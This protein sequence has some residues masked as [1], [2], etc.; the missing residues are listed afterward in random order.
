M[1]EDALL[2]ALV[3]GTA[4][5]TGLPFFRALVQGLSDALGTHGAWITEYLPEQRRLW[6]IALRLGG[7]WIPHYEYAVAGTPCGYSIEQRE[8]LFVKDRVADLFPGDNDLRPLGAVSY[9]GAGIFDESGSRVLGHLAVLHTEPMPDSERYTRIFRVFANR[10]GAELPRLIVEREQRAKSEELDGE[11]ESAMDAILILNQDH[12]IVR[13]NAA[14]AAA[15]GTADLAGEMVDRFVSVQGAEKLEPLLQDLLARAGDDHRQLWIPGGVEARSAAGDKF[16]V[17]GT[18]SRFELN[19]NRFATLI[20]RNISDR[21]AAEAKLRR[22]TDQSDYLREE[23]DHAF[24]EIIGESPPMRRLVGEITEVAR[25]DVSVLISGETGTG[26]EL[27]ARAVHRASRRSAAPLIKVNCAAIP[28]QLIESEFFGHEKGAFTGALARR[29]GRFS[30]ADGGTLFLDEIGELP[31]GL[32]AKLLRVLQEGEFEPVGSSRTVKV[33]VRV[34]AATNRDLR[35][36]STE[37]RFREDLYYR[38]SVFPLHAPAL[39]TRGRDIDLL[40]LE[41][42][43][44][45]CERHGRPAAAVTSADLERLRAYAWPGNVRELANVIERALITGDGTRWNLDRALPVTGAPPPPTTEAAD[46][47]LTAREVEEFETANLLRALRT[48]RG[49]ISGSGGAAALLG[50]KPTTLRSRLKVLG[51]QPQVESSPPR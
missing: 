46:R 48:A 39:R 22:L 31:L 37:G 33:D 34:I 28:E 19:G 18:L 5:E 8:L 32:Q 3:E 40:A 30:L 23:L 43:R 27:V 24:G 49:R 36:E 15:F 7:E 25:T 10:A 12:E 45:F 51:I 41:F 13:A 16:A 44:R 26:K 38:L 1:N 20:L 47:V 42:S 4:G 35:I 29:E 17:E 6:A 21:L 50:L 14:A 9:I 2:R 11:V